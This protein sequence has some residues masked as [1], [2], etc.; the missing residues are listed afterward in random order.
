M[1]IH[2][3]LAQNLSI[4]IL[5]ANDCFVIKSVFGRQEE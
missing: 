5:F 2:S 1:H 4:Q 3:V